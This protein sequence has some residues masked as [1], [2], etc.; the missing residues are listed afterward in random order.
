M[1]R[2]IKILA[3]LMAVPG[4]CLASDGATNPAKKASPG[5]GI[6]TA[7]VR[8]TRG[9]LG[10]R[11][12]DLDPSL[13]GHF[14]LT[15]G[16]RGVLVSDV[17]AGGPA[18]A[19]G[20][21]PGDVI[22]S[23]DGKLVGG[24]QDLRH[25]VA[26]SPEGDEVALGI[27]RESALL[28]LTVKIGAKALP[29]GAAI[30]PSGEPGQQLGLVVRALTQPE[31]Q[32]DG[33]DFG[34][35][36]EAVDK[37]SPAE[38]AGIQAGDVILELEHARVAGPEELGRL[39]KLLK[40]GDS[41]LV[42]LQHDGKSAYLS[43]PLPEQPAAA[44]SASGTLLTPITIEYGSGWVEDVGPVTY[45][46]GFT[47]DGLRLR[48]RGD[49]QQVIDPLAD[50]KASQLIRSSESEEVWGIGLFLAGG[51]S[52]FAGVGNLVYQVVNP[53]TSTDQY[54]DKEENFPNLVPFFV[55]FTG[56]L[57]TGISGAVLYGGRSDA[58]RTAAVE[59]YNQVVNSLKSLSLFELPDSKRLGLAYNRTF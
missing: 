10:I 49:L 4:L 51:V 27:W 46:T 24:Q 8:S 20:L 22:Q 2:F 12:Q 45:V 52:V 34:A 30:V 9:W 29:D 35:V 59:R 39:S 7:L 31:Q 17:K 36:V 19:A 13:A 58:N 32:Q 47:H 1:R 16:A 38:G 26:S 48:H 53:T 42:R 57:I 44:I 41:A 23:F 5:T 55:L 6:S 40:A 54:G 3:L 11:M 50:A 18:Q 43:V 15:S 33:L 28:K 37:G 14:G 21:K 25:F 56:G